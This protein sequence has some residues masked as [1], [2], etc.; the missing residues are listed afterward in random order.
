MAGSLLNAVGLPELITTTDQ[1]YESLALDLAQNREILNKIRNKLSRNIKTNPLF[2]TRRYTRNL[3]LGFEMAY[4]RY[5]QGK[6]PEHIV[7]TD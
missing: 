4:D 6:C 7:V 2:D 5:L 3:E 1:E